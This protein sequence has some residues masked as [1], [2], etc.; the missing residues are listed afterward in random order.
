MMVS[1]LI[2]LDRRV[3]KRRTLLVEA[4]DKESLTRRLVF[5]DTNPRTN[6]QPLTKWMAI[7]DPNDEDYE[8]V[9]NEY[10][11]ITDIQEQ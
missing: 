7:E 3:I 5:G 4:P 11:F 8:S 6:H 2:T 9:W 1:Y 10:T